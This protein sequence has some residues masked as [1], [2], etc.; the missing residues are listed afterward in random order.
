VLAPHLL[1]PIELPPGLPHASPDLDATTLKEP[2]PST[3]RTGAEKNR[4]GFE[5]KAGNTPRLM[6]LAIIVLAALVIALGLTIIM[7]KS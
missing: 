3:T 7:G 1:A 6:M 5:P 2:L 4:R